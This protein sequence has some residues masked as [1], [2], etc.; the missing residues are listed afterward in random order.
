MPNLVYDKYYGAYD[1]RPEAGEGDPGRGNPGVNGEAGIA[2]EDATLDIIAAF[3]M[4]LLSFDM[5][6]L[7]YH[8]KVN[9]P[10]PLLYSSSQRR[11]FARQ[12]NGSKG[13]SYLSATQRN[14]LRPKM[15]YAA[16]YAELWQ[17]HRSLENTLVLST[18]S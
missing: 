5:A 14:R 3:W 4:I 11:Y 18:H 6:L 10:M 15:R 9:I 7:G 8:S 12:L 1:E 2:N 13:S 16:L 17:N